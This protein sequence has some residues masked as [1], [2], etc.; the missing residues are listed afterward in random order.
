MQG[1]KDAA[2]G[3][4]Q[5]QEGPASAPPGGGKRH[6]TIRRARTWAKLA[7]FVSIVAGLFAGVGWGSLSSAGIDAIAYVCPLG[8]L[9][10]LLASKAAV[11]RFTVALV[12][13]VALV[14]LFGRAWCSWICPVPPIDSF[15]HYRKDAAESPRGSDGRGADVAR[16]GHGPASAASASEEPRDPSRASLELSEGD[17][18]AIRSQAAELL[19]GRAAKGGCAACGLEPVGGSR[20]GLRLDTRHGVLAGALVGSLVCGFPV[21]C[22]VC[23]VGL[24]IATVVAVWQ[25]FWGHAP[26]WSLVVFPAIVLAEV[27][28]FRK[29]CHVLCPMGALMSLVGQ[30]SRFQPKVDAGKCLR[31]RGVDCRVCVNSCPEKLDPHS[32][33][34]P[35][36]TKCGI[37]AENCPGKAIR[38]TSRRESMARRDSI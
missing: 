37:C 13:M 24:S 20:D 16:A 26:S 4:A 38:M 1:T 23:P 35:E 34:I 25:L 9:E 2:A 29:W 19:G 7:V 30:K 11:P 3:A 17:K 28:F 21:F 31:G 6:A 15:F 22:L 10:A 36:C 32:A 18:A 8:S 33:R 5:P 27:V 12:A 14:A